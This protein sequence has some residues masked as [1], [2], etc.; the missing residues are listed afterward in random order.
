M[1]DERER[2]YHCVVGHSIRPERLEDETAIWI[3]DAGARVRVC[4]EHGTPI[5]VTVAPAEVAR[6]T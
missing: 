4:L 5:A 6:T 2:T 3:L 1:T